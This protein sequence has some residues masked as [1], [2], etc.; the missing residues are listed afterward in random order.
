MKTKIEELL[1]DLE[2]LLNTYN[3]RFWL[4]PPIKKRRKDEEVTR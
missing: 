1:E 3:G 4:T 2:K